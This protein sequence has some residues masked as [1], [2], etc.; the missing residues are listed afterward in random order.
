MRR[1]AKNIIIGIVICT[2]VILTL[3]FKSDLFGV[4]ESHLEKDARASQRISD[5]WEVSKSVNESLAA[6]I[7]YNETL[8][9]YIFS[10][11]VKRDGVSFGYFF[12]YGGSSGAIIDGIQQFSFGDKGSVLISMNKNKVS[13]IEINNG[14]NVSQIDIDPGK[15]FAAALLENC[16]SVKLYDMGNNEITIT[17]EENY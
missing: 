12:K 5:T 8:D 14:V 16:G 3:I 9:D 7:F 15:P 1:S 13:R 2:V 10:I 4:L 17:N 6:M 11:Y